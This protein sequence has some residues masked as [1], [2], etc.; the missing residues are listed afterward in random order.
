M[1]FSEETELGTRI[2]IIG[3][4]G[5]GKSSLARELAARTHLP[6]FHLDRLF[7]HPGWEPTPDREWETLQ[8]NLVRGPEWIIDGNYARTLYLRVR[9][10]D[11]VVFLDVPRIA[12]MAGVLHRI[13]KGWGRERIDMAPGCPERLDGEFLNYVW[14]FQRH[15]RP[16][17]LAALNSLGSHQHVIHLRSRKEARVWLTRVAETPRAGAPVSPTRPD[18][19]L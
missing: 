12:A 4:P 3:S 7:W 19:D 10:A 13:L 15:Q 14:Q 6:L 16:L 2:C 18:T 11:T 17:V 1:Y 9:A 5:A 8:Q